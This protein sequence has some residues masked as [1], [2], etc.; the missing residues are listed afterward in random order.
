MFIF[1]FSTVQKNTV[2]FSML[3]NCFVYRLLSNA[4][5]PGDS[6]LQNFKDY[7]KHVMSEIFV[8]SKQR[9]HRIAN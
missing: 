7:A 5:V 8:L 4:G 6:A 3:F 1:F 9:H 2:F